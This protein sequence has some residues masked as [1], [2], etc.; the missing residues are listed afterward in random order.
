MMFLWMKSMYQVYVL[1]KVKKGQKAVNQ[2]ATLTSD[3]L[4]SWS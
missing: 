4:K 3:E 2:G 1:S